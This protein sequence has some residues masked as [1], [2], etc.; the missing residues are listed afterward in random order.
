MIPTNCRGIPKHY[1]KPK[2]TQDRAEIKKLSLFDWIAR[3]SYTSASIVAEIWGVDSSV[4]NRALRRYVNEGYLTEVP[5]TCC[6]D[7]RL[8]ILKPKAVKY[9]N[10]YHLTPIRYNTKRSNLPLKVI[11][12]ELVVQLFLAL[13]IT[14][15]KF[16]YFITEKEQE[17]DN[18]GKNRRVDAIVFDIELG[19]M[20][21]IEV[22][23]S[24][25]SIPHRVDLLKKYQKALIDDKLYTRVV[26]VS[27][28]RRHLRDCERVNN[29]ILTKDEGVFFKTEQLSSCLKYLYNKQIMAILYH[30]IW[31]L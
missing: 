22:E 26:F 28:K 2:S 21:A 12:H 9:I 18:K 23:C 19:E 29:K 16:F 24:S 31:D 8:F 11:N 10:N 1:P 27:F 5:I 30:K 6:R 4:V 13:N 15:G 14:S 17:K 25:K 20:I 3:F 7:K